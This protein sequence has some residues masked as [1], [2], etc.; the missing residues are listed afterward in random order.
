MD[1]KRYENAVC[2]FNTALFGDDEYSFSVLARILGR[3]CRLTLTDGERFV[4]CHSAYPYPVWVWAMRGL[5]VSEYEEIYSILKAEF[6]GER[7]IRFNTGYEFAEFI[8]K[9]AAK[10]GF[11]LEIADNMFA[12]RCDRVIPPKKA[13]DGRMIKATEEYIETAAGYL[14]DFSVT[15]GN[16]KW[17]LEDCRTKARDFINDGRLFFWLDG[18]GEIGAMASF[19]ISDDKGSVGSVYTPPEKRRH[20]YASCLVYGITRLIIEKGKIPTLYTDAD[21]AASNACYTAIGYLKMG[22]LCALKQI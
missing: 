1:I 14:F 19:D 4:I 7:D 6:L 11:L 21:Y 9:R 22:A 5:S 10:D 2:P 20:G 3:A 18:K 12:Y 15:V 16:E 13:A 8:T 17:T